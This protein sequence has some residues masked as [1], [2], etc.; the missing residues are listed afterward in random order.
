MLPILVV[1]PFCRGDKKEAERLLAWIAE[2]GQVDASCALMAAQSCDPLSMLPLAKQAFTKA[3]VWIDAEDI[4][5]NWKGPD[6]SGK[7]AS[8]PN[9]IFRQ[10]AWN[11][12]V[13]KRGPWLFLEP[14]S[15]PLCRDWL[16]RICDEYERCGKPFMGARVDAKT[17]P[18]S[19]P[20]PLHMSGVA[21]YPQTTPRLAPTAV[22][23]SVNA[24]DVM[25]AREMLP[26]AHFTNLIH[27]HYRAPAFATM[28]QVEARIP[29]EAVLFHA[30]KDGSLIPFL[31]Q[32]LKGGDAS[33]SRN[34]IHLPALSWG[35]P[36]FN[37]EGAPVTD[38]FIKSYP[39]D[40]EWLN[41]CLRS[42]DKHASGFR[43]VV[44]YLPDHGDGLVIPL[45][46]QGR[47]NIKCGADSQPGY[48]W[49]QVVKLDADAATDA[50]FILYMDSDCIFTRD[51]TPEDFIKDGKP[52]WGYAKADAI[53]DDQR[54]TWFPV[55]EKFL[56]KTPEAE[57]MRRHP[58]C[59]H[60]SMLQ[61]V[62]Q[63]CRYAHGT[64]LSAYIMAQAKPGNP[65]HLGFSEWNCLGFFLHEFHRDKVH[66]VEQGSAEWAPECVHQ[67]W[68]HGGLT[69]EI[70]AKLEAMLC[71]DVH[72]V[73]GDPSTEVAKIASQETHGIATVSDAIE[74][75]L[76]EAHRDGFAKGRILKQLRTAGLVKGG[77]LREP[78]TTIAAPPRPL[79]KVESTFL[80][81]IHSYPGA[82]EAFARHFPYYEK[83]G[84][85]RIVGIGTTDGKCVFPDGIESVQIG[86]NKY[87]HG[88]HLPR[89][90]ID[91]IRWCLTQPED[92]FC[93]AEYDVLF[94][95]AI[96]SKWTGFAADLTGGQL[97]DAKAK[98]FFHSP[99]MFD[100]P[101]GRVIADELERIIADGHCQ[102]AWPECSPDVTL[103][104][105]A[106]RLDMKV[107]HSLFRHFTRNS[108]DIPGDLEKA[109]T[110]VR[111]G[112]DTLHGV[113]TL[114]EFNAIVSAS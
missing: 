90:L 20:V 97:K 29:K 113:K 9:S 67:E 21:V 41:Y 89:R 78:K 8:G 44:L 26:Q 24:F 114:A 91:T 47:L 71:D 104:L 10:C 98:R 75:L 84:A 100:K 23:H 102:Y 106:D 28:Q 48:L 11:A 76:R 13:Q 3:E 79:P 105:A 38:I 49:Q 58:F 63:Y 46:L 66:W 50:D 30:N 61:D 88:E 42:I 25:A 112:V 39:K 107:D 19:V 103:G 110:A 108:L 60:R 85:S 17:H 45:G 15:V 54:K 96:P 53:R 93:I 70:R 5:S 37:P 4:Q 27:H 87:I 72:G 95:K 55:M 12:S 57:F 6:G 99:W 80:L 82:N 18:G 7:D 65:L 36:T 16:S 56:R 77:K 92:R 73:A 111:D 43:N 59:V 109:I 68:S 74:L 81:A 64:E 40:Y 1:V 34:S 2:L 31:R 62:R 32:K 94:L 51:V 14:D 101:T 69:N 86:D 83:S 33:L 35:A 22:Q 52:V